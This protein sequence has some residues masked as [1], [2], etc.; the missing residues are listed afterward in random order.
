MRVLPLASQYSSVLADAL[1]RRGWDSV[2]AQSAAHGV[3]TVAFLF[4]GVSEE[5]RESLANLFHHRGIECLTGDGWVL[6]LSSLSRVA[7][8]ARPGFSPLPA[9]VAECIGLCLNSLGEPPALWRTGRGSVSLDQ[10]RVVGILN[11]TPDSFSDGG[12]FLRPDAALAHAAYMV[13]AGVDI[14][15]VGAESTRPG[16]GHELLPGEEWRRLQPV[17]EGLVDR[18]PELEISVDTV[19][20]ETARRALQ[21]GVSIVN[22]V[23]GFRLD[24]EMA[25]VCAEGGA[26]VVLMHSRGGVHDMAS[27]QHAEYTDLL[28]EV[29]A[30]LEEGCQD[31]KAAG[32]AGESIVV[33]PGLGFAKRPD[34]NYAI[35]RQLSVIASLGYPVMVGPSRKR[36]LRQPPED[37]MELADDVTAAACALAFTDGAALFRVHDVRR[38]RAALQVAHLVRG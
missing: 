24:P 36:F 30:E 13:A 2:R 27:Y 18:F 29:T 32:V 9:E 35:L 11:V 20:S 14:I 4:D 16:A 31:A 15:D 19:K 28:A 6:I 26:G 17:L 12:R 25:G 22:D 10:P 5:L 34:H 23:S 7:G 21:V 1:M 3:Q 33:D 8:L 38:T 37:G